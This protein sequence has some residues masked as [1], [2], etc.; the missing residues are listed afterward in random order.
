MDD[1][2]RAA[3]R[4]LQTAE[5]QGLTDQARK[6][7]RDAGTGGFAREA[8]KAMRI[9]ETQGFAQH[10]ADA[11]RR[12]NG[13]GM[14]Q[15]AVE[16][17]RTDDWRQPLLGRTA[18]DQFRSLLLGTAG[19]DSAQSVWQQLQDQLAR[20][21]SKDTERAF[22]SL[23]TTSA[24]IGE[25]LDLPGIVSTSE[26]VQSLANQAGQIS[27]AVANT[28]WGRALAEQFSQEGLTDSFIEDLIDYT[29]DELE[30]DSLA[31]DALELVENV[32]LPNDEDAVALIRL[33]LPIVTEIGLKSPPKSAA[34][35]LVFGTLLITVVSANP[36]VG[37]LAAIA[38]ALQQFANFMVNVYEGWQK[39]IEA[40]KNTDD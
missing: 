13:P 26:Y 7:L 5:K 18:E 30:N 6:A 21:S 22:A 9:T 3:I 36:E 20:S 1:A 40:E 12:N 10:A 27:A 31:D 16:R 38:A 33:L 35:M 15:Q 34:S 29:T 24:G 28:D 8:V 14:I 32:P 23:S 11:I 25:L 17:M 19:Q 2:T 4:R 37:K 39:Q